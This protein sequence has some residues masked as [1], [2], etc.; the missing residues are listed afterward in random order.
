MSFSVADVW[1]NWEQ[2]EPYYLELGK[3]VQSVLKNAIFEGG[4]YADVTFRPKE[5]ISILK[6]LKKRNEKESFSYND[7]TDKLGVRVIC[8]YQEDIPLI[9]KIIESLFFVN[10]FDNKGEDLSHNTLDYVSYHYDLIYKQNEN[11]RIN[12]LIFELQLRTI[13]Q[14]A[15]ACTAHELSYKQDVELPKELKRKV[16]RLL[17]LYEIA[18]NELSSVNKFI[19]NHED[20]PLYSCF[21]KL[22]KTFY[23]LAKSTFDREQSINSLKSIISFLSVSELNIFIQDFDTFIVQYSQK[24][25]EIFTEYKN[26]TNYN[27]I[28]LQP[29]VVF[30]W[31]LLDK[32]EYKLKENWAKYF[33]EN[34]LEI[35]INS[36]AVIE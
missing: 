23:Q 20:F 31:F 11:A 27:Y 18:D 25:Q 7:M 5:I 34:D 16:Y 21:K 36:W 10:K 13:N 4:M 9:Q 15:W 33:D 8:N 19:S 12:N 28:I 24:I 29:E 22:E 30:V 14:H 1:K 26:D 3:S 17:A 32:C 2:D 35:I 6:K